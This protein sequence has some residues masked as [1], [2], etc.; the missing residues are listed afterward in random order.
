MPKRAVSKTV[1]SD[2]KRATG[3][4]KNKR[5]VKSPEAKKTSVPK[6]AAFKKQTPGGGAGRPKK[7]K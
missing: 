6:V 7:V 3:T 1:R 4:A 2:D 5:V